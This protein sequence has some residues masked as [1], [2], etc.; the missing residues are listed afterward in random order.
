MIIITILK[1]IIRPIYIAQ[2]LC[3]CIHVAKVTVIQ[4]YCYLIYSIM[5]VNSEAVLERKRLITNA[6]ELPPPSPPPPKK[7]KKNNIIIIKLKKP[8]PMAPLFY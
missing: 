8:L 3:K 2:V 6:I 5:R 4:N 7:K 1:Q